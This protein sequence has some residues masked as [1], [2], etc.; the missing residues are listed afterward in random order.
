M[1]FMQGSRWDQGGRAANGGIHANDPDTALQ[2]SQRLV[3]GHPLDDP[4]ENLAGSLGR[5]ALWRR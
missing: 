3:K 5:H 4:G 2:G 1:R